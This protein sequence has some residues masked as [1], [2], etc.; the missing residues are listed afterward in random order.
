M[1]RV[2]EVKNFMDDG[3]EI[4]IKGKSQDELNKITGYVNDLDTKGM[5]K[6]KELEKIKKGNYQE[7]PNASREVINL[8]LI[9]PQ[10]IIIVEKGESMLDVAR[11]VVDVVEFSVES[12]TGLSLISFDREIETKDRVKEL[13]EYLKVYTSWR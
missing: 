7:I 12:P 5:A 13:I 8:P 2:S 9:K 3:W 11:K 4:N 1:A 6:N 10:G